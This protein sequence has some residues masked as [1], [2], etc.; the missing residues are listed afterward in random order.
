MNLFNIK[1]MPNSIILIL[2]IIGAIITVVVAVG[3][4]Y[5]NESLKNDNRV[6]DDERVLILK[7][8]LMNDLDP[9]KPKLLKRAKSILEKRNIDKNLD[10]ILN[11]KIDD[12]NKVL[13]AALNYFSDQEYLKSAKV[14]KYLESISKD[15]YINAVSK[16]FLGS[17]Y[18]YSIKDE[19]ENPKKYLL[20]ALTNLEKF[21][22]KSEEYFVIKAFTHTDLGI[23]YKQNSKIKE[24]ETQYLTALKVYKKLNILFPNE[25]NIN[26]GEQYQN[27]YSL[28][29]GFGKL[30]EL[31]LNEAYLHKKKAFEDNPN[32]ISTYLNTISSLGLIYT[33][34]GNFNKAKHYFDLGE[35]LIEDVK[36][37]N[38]LGDEFLLKSIGLNNNFSSYYRQKASIDNHV[39]NLKLSKFYLIKNEE[40]FENLKEFNGSTSLRSYGTNLYALGLV[41]QE[42]EVYDKALEYYL[43]AEKIRLDLSKMDND[44]IGVFSE[45][46]A[47][48]YYGLANIYSS[49]RGGVDENKAKT[50]A[51]KA[52]KIYEDNLKYNPIL[53]NYI[54]SMESIINS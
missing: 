20:S 54:N 26:I 35:K 8:T 27:I 24:S 34:K 7:I 18:L 2:I 10:N 15:K 44:N 39:D 13:L 33:K 42:L 12:E 48:V 52:L 30:D 6:R 49:V 40:I 16:S 9:R 1:K 28:H 47:H 45:E 25:Y 3:R 36:N 50:Y 53:K 11:G 22:S 21:N 46:L 37:K 19:N 51:K 38:T 14:F 23:Y 41:N 4:Y 31:S 29:A 43:R 5:N 17:I 32:Y